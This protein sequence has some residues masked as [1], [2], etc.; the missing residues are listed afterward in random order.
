VAGRGAGPA[1]L[2]LR[3]R[4]VPRA[5]SHGSRHR[6]RRRRNR[7]RPRQR[8]GVVRRLTA[9]P[10]PHGDDQNAGGVRRHAPPPRDDRGRRRRRRRGGRTCRDDRAVGRSGGR[11][12]VRPP[13]RQVGRRPQGLRR[14]LDAA[15]GARCAGACRAYASPDALCRVAISGA[16][17]PGGPPRRAGRRNAALL[18]TAGC[19]GSRRRRTPCGAR[20]L[21]R[22][23]EITAC[24]RR[25]QRPRGGIDGTRSGVPTASPT[26]AGPCS[27]V[28]AREA[29]IRCGS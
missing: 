1:W 27:R 15:A 16:C 25:F 6:S 12:A 10:R 19:D 14:S 24:R 11:R 28:G 3:R 20:R 22:D 29:C 2:R 7:A 21:R 4:G 13:R 5:R 8:N 23:A 26:G 17:E 18:A 9:R